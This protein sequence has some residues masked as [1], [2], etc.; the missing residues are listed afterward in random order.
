MTFRWHLW[1]TEPFLCL[2]SGFLIS[3]PPPSLWAFGQV[4][5]L[6]DPLC[7]QLLLASTGPEV[8]QAS[9]CHDTNSLSRAN[10]RAMARYAA[11]SGVTIK[12][13]SDRQTERSK[14]GNGVMGLR[15]TSC[16]FM[17]RHMSR[18][19]KHFLVSKS[20]T[21]HLCAK[22]STPLKERTHSS[23]VWH[24]TCPWISSFILVEFYCGHVLLTNKNIAAVFPRTDSVSHLI[25]WSCQPY[26]CLMLLMVSVYHSMQTYK[27]IIVKWTNGGLFDQPG[28]IQSTS[29]T[30]TH[31]HCLCPILDYLGST[32]EA[33]LP[34]WRWSATTLY[35][36]YGWH[37]RNK[38][39]VLK[40]H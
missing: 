6:W 29:T 5:R 37:H 8:F 33:G 13:T 2:G 40:G 15:G 39:N 36:T 1:S 12:K 3:P 7:V 28:F 27:A 14:S 20:W 32:V 21:V 18:I 10:C 38:I 11:D 35:E 24:F 4:F 22:S 31:T 25:H 19:C 30:H 9:C 26:A 16:P 17:L 34:R 23:L